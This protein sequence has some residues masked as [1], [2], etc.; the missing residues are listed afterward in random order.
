MKTARAYKVIYAD[1][2]KRDYVV[3][4]RRGMKRLERERKWMPYEAY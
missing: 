1:S 3:A 2:I 4:L